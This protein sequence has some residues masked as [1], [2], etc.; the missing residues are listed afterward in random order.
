MYKIIKHPDEVFGN[1]TV[2][3]ILNKISYS[4]T[5]ENKIE[6]AFALHDI[7]LKDGG[8]INLWI[9]YNAVQNTKGGFAVSVERWIIYDEIPD[10]VLD[11]YL[12][13]KNKYI[14]GLYLTVNSTT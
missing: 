11:R 14:V 2:S 4:V 7:R 5:I 13:I 6:G 8:L 12:E 1:E 3:Y 10:I 9:E